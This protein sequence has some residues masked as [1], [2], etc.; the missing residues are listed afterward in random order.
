[1]SFSGLKLQLEGWE[2]HPVT[3]QIKAR[4]ARVKVFSVFFI[5]QSMVFAKIYTMYKMRRD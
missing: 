1:L 4:D 3:P 5:P 2:K